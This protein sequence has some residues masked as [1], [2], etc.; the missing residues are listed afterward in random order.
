MKGLVRLILGLMLLAVAVTTFAAEG[1]NAKKGKYLY[2]KDCRTCHVEGGGAKA[3]TPMSKTQ[4]QWNRQFQ[5]V[6]H[7][8]QAKAWKGLSE[9]DIKDIQ[10]YLINHAAD[11]DQPETCG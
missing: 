7:P 8:D 4:A 1:G 10:Q 3:L 5:K 11:S 9:Q 2:K 6:T